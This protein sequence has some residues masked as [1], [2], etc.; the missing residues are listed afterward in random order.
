MMTKRKNKKR[1]PMKLA[2][3]VRFERRQWGSE[4]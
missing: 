1:N 4:S 3:P 2:K